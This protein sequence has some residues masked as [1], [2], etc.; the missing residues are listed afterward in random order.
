[1]LQTLRRPERMSL[2][3]TLATCSV[4]LNAT[5]RDRSSIA[6][7]ISSTI[8]DGRGRA[9]R[10][11][12]SVCARGRR[13]AGSAVALVSDG[14]SRLPSALAAPCEAE[15]IAAKMQRLCAEWHTRAIWQGQGQ[16]LSIAV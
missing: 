12:V 14:N 8:C 11:V 9:Q 16:C 6:P 10:S 15:D 7:G 3:G 2:S 4:A 13:R 1:M 5:E